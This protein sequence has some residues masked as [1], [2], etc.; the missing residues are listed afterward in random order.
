MSLCCKDSDE[1]VCAKY[2]ELEYEYY[3]AQV[4]FFEADY[5]EE[6]IIDMQARLHSADVDEPAMF[7]AKVL[8]ERQ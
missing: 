5:F 1:I 4:S 8:L 3:L 6:L 7:P 2:L